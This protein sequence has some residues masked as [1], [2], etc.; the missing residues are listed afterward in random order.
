MNQNTGLEM[1]FYLGMKG[2]GSFDNIK[3]TTSPF[4]PFY[5]SFPNL[6]LVFCFMYIQ[7][8]QINTT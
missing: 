1:S 6:C 8:H 2:E 4:C 5:V 7:Y 3:I